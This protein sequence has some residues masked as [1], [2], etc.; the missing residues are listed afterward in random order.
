MRVRRTGRWIQT[1]AMR[2]AV[3]TCAARA[4]GE[5]PV[6][7]SLVRDGKPTATI[8]LGDNAMRAAQFAAAELQHHIKKITG[9][10]LPIVSD[11]NA[12]DGARILV[13]E[14][15]QTAGLN[16]PGK[17][18]EAQEYLIRFLTNTV[19]LMGYDADRRTQVAYDAND[20]SVYATWPD[21]FEEQ[22]T[23]YAV[24]DF[25]ERCCG[26]RWFR[27]GE[28]G[29]VC[30][31]SST[32]E[33]TGP[34]VRRSPEFKHRKPYPLLLMTSDYDRS[35]GLWDW[36]FG[37]PGADSGKRAEVEALAYPELKGKSDGAKFGM[38][39]L[40]LHRMRLGG[41]AAQYN[42]AFYGYYDR[43]WQKNPKRPELFEAPHPEWF[44]QGYGEKP[45]PIK[46][47]GKTYPQTYYEKPPQMCFSN[48][49][50]I[51][52]VVRDARDYF[53]GKGAKP[54][55]A[56]EGDYFSV[57]PMDSPLWCK[58][59]ACQKLVKEEATRGQGKYS[60]DRASDYVFTFA[61][62]VARE[63]AKTHPN[64]YLF[65]PGYHEYAYPPTGF[66]LEHNLAH[67]FCL[68]V[69]AVYSREI[70][71]ND[72]VILKTWHEAAAS[73][74]SIVYLYYLF[75]VYSAKLGHFNCFP[76]FF[77][78]SVDTW[79]KLFHQ[80][81][82]RGAFFEGLGHDV[83]VYVTC[84][85]MDDPTQKIDTLLDDYFTGLYGA[86]AA[87]MKDFYLEV[88]RIFADPANYPDANGAQTA[89][90]AWDRL[91]TEARMASLARHMEAAR[92]VARTDSEKARVALFD[93]QIWEYMTVGRQRY[94]E[95]KRTAIPSVKASRVP[96]AG[97]DTA[98]VDWSK[99][100]AIRE[101]S[102]VEGGAADRKLEARLAHDDGFLY[103][104]L[105]EQVDPKTLKIDSISV[106]SG[107]DWELLFSRQRAKPYRQLGLGPY[108]L[109][110]G[111][112]QGEVDGRPQS[113][114]DSGAVVR[115]DVSTGDRWTTWVAL[116]LAKLLPGGLKPGDT[117]H[118]NVIRL[119][120]ASGRARQIAW[121]PLAGVNQV[122]RLG[123]VTLE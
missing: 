67:S 38:V 51:R 17:P 76:G 77:A 4:W 71:E 35:T 28:L 11:T 66:R 103:M 65:I 92:A 69:R 1:T 22:G 61:N 115:S 108:G 118:M 60:N 81:G 25:L 58:C 70:Q 111:V 84:K 40:F 29:T 119:W 93:K 39:R 42:H 106:W 101:W 102:Q 117:F 109:S 73:N 94:L 98:K 95:R 68:H 63:V 2:V 64:K 121:V 26:V 112:A 8:V 16:L 23:C 50:F 33:V 27:P 123:E 52:Q 74:R 13:G 62:K 85:L 45:S 105:V 122:D 55:A 56:A 78:H 75:P 9:A 91:G 80:Y 18:F 88:E 48:P 15:R 47:E 104:Q 34:E 89:E 20:P 37:V 53:D 72:R 21:F 114:W 44:A 43:F 5:A 6:G 3:A 36:G 10:T 110:E 49:D 97:G 31:A 30:P 32:L 24:Y 90:V 14:S 19:V 100:P 7:V 41:E 113:A 12:V 79:F 86:A 87:P 82:F 59:P 99:A 46:E 54:G 57:A 116:P 83:E 120:W 107:D 96:N